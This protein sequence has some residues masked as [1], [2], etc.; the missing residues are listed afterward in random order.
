VR[1]LIEKRLIELAQ[2]WAV[3]LPAAARSSFTSSFFRLVTHRVQTDAALAAARPLRERQ[4]VADALLM[5][6]SEE[7]AFMLEARPEAS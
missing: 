7:F 2:A 1:D 6:G 5:T 4:V 3:D